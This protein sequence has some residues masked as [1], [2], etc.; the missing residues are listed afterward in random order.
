MKKWKTLN[1]NKR[2]KILK[3]TPNPSKIKSMINMKEL[4]LPESKKPGGEKSLF[5]LNLS[6]S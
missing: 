5:N 2:K 6:E 3:K 1:Q 4:T